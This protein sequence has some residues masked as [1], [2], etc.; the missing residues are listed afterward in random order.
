M[1]P[2]HPINHGLLN[3][4]E[5]MTVYYVCSADDLAGLELAQN[6]EEQLACKIV[7]AADVYGDIDTELL[8]IKADSEHGTYA[9]L[10]SAAMYSIEV[11]ASNIQ[12][13]KTE[14]EKIHEYLLGPQYDNGHFWRVYRLLAAEI[15]RYDAICDQ[16]THF[17]GL[18]KEFSYTVTSQVEESIREEQI[19]FVNL[20]KTLYSI[21]EIKAVAS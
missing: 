11:N 12:I 13:W 7:I 4:E 10:K 18:S 1:K 19:L 15:G 17:A 16:S 14:A 2:C 20:L 8:A 21:D 3:R 5:L 6:D 9:S